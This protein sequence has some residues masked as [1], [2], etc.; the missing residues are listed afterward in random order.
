M[1][2]PL[3]DQFYPGTVHSEEEDGRLNIH[4]DDGGIENLDM[5]KEVW[6]FNDTISASSASTQTELQVTSTENSVLASMLEHFG[7]KPFLR[8]HAQGFDQYL[9]VNAYKTEEDTFL[10]TVRPV[11]HTE[12]LPT[13]MLLA[14]TRYTKLRPMMTGL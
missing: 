11:P 8:H 9:L 5:S 7:N 10:K 4:Y 6:K 12:V 13:P 1:F 14:V 2:W 3:D